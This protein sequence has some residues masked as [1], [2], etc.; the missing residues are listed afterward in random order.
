VRSVDVVLKMGLNDRFAGYHK[1]CRSVE[2]S[3]FTR[4]SRSLKR[5][6]R[7]K[8]G[9]KT[10]PK[11]QEEVKAYLCR[12]IMDSLP[13]VRCCSLAC[14][15]WGRVVSTVRFRDAIAAIGIRG[16]RASGSILIG[17]WGEG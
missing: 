11:C 1:L 9:K 6:C 14:L 12:S 15:W 17:P 5:N 2:R 8:E 7:E 13:M 4:R 3:L 16:S 10:C